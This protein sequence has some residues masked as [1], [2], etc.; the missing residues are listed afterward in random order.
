MEGSLLTRALS[1]LTAMVVMLVAM[2]VMTAT[3][4]A[5]AAGFGANW[6][7]NEK[8]GPMVDSS[9]RGNDG[10]VKGGV[11]RTGSGYRF[12][13]RTGYVTVP[14][15]A[16]LNPGSAGATIEVKFSLDSA[17]PTGYDYDIVRKGLAGT[18]GGDYKMEVLASGA[19]LCRFRGS[20]AAAEVRGGTNLGVGTHVV[21]CVKTNSS[22]ELWVD[23]NRKATKPVV[24]GSISN[25]QPVILA[26]KPG[27][28]YTKGLIDYIKIL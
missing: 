24:V 9:G 23:G 26:A 14:N 25:T 5:L 3:G 22:V 16:S 28:D 21:R 6:Q 17:P 8:S 20:T 15:S 7:M 1:R 11:T 27:D 2:S 12:D 19:A 13:G 18:R 10:T 4:Q